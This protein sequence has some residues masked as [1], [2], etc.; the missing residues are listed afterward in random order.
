M[1]FSFFFLLQW[2]LQALWLF[3]IMPSLRSQGFVALTT[4]SASRLCIFTS[5]WLPPQSPPTSLSSISTDFFSPPKTN[6]THQVCLSSPPQPPSFL[7]L[8]AFDQE[9][10]CSF[11]LLPFALFCIYS[12]IFSPFSRSKTL[13]A[14]DRYDAPGLLNRWRG[15]FCSSPWGHQTLC[16]SAC[17]RWHPLRASSTWTC[18][19]RVKAMFVHAAVFRSILLTTSVHTGQQKR[20]WIFLIAHKHADVF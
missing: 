17:L 8:S 16:L 10:V 6:F 5:L 13:F 12:A 9:P 3:F 20:C 19:S 18:S 1:M 2:F 4:P 15:Y 7:H 11:L 14:P